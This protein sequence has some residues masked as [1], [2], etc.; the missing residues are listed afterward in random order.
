LYIIKNTQEAVLFEEDLLTFRIKERS[1]DFG[2]WMGIEPGFVK[3]NFEWKQ[4]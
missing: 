3:T 1:K 4:L 2:E